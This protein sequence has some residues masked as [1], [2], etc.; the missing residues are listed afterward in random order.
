MT[1][2]FHPDLD[3]F[4]VVVCTFSSKSFLCYQAQNSSSFSETRSRSKSGPMLPCN[5]MEFGNAHVQVKVPSRSLLRDSSVLHQTHSLWCG[6][7]M[8]TTLM[9]CELCLVKAVIWDPLTVL[10]SNLAYLHRLHEQHTLRCCK[11]RFACHASHDMSALHSSLFRM[12]VCVVY[13]GI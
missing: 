6:D 9:S 5:R 8:L 11:S 13:L 1:I 4:S 10:F 2:Q 3:S 7:M 12:H